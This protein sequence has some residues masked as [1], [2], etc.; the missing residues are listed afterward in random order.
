ME[1]CIDMAVVTFGTNIL[2]LRVQR[3]LERTT[4]KLA[5]GYDRLSS[6]LR[7]NKASDD[8]AGLAMA[9]KLKADNKVYGQGIRNTNDAIS[10]LQVSQG[11]LEQLSSV[12]TRL[13]ELAQQSA[14]GVFSLIQ[15]RALQAEADELVDE[16]NRITQSTKF[17]RIALIDGSLNQLNVQTGYGTDAAIVFNLGEDL[18]RNQGLGSFTL[19]GNKTGGTPSSTL[20]CNTSKEIVNEVL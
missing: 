19:D 15:R 18:Q 10:A 14:N 5:A 7:I 13:K 12:V 3:Q 11:A 4:S 17:N 16:Y 20:R 2:S 9:A 1:K 6:G 8:S